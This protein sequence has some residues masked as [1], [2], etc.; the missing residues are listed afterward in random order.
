MFL[1]RKCGFRFSDQTLRNPVFWVWAK[2]RESLAIM[3]F[4]AQI[5]DEGLQQALLTLRNRIGIFG[6]DFWNAIRVDE[7]V[8]LKYATRQAVR[9]VPLSRPFLLRLHFV[10]DD[11]RR[12][13]QR[14]SSTKSPSQLL[15]RAL[16]SLF[17]LPQAV[18]ASTFA[19]ST[20]N[21]HFTCYHCNF[22]LFNF[23]AKTTQATS[24]QGKR[25][26]SRPQSTGCRRIS[27]R[28]RSSGTLNF[29]SAAEQRYPNPS[30]NHGVC[31]INR[32]C[33]MRSNFLFRCLFRS[34]S[35]Y[36]GVT[37]CWKPVQYTGYQDI[38]DISRIPD[39]W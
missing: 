4:S 29:S 33:L 3:Y 1:T 6:S 19:S 14:H 10:C 24:E 25:H 34:P 17:Y 22:L 8:G 37:S 26:L 2:I 16:H 7:G 30:S 12:E 27:P 9:Q 15:M 13:W 35:W 23:M 5:I 38:N 28:R 11:D 20:S 31:P 36:Q 39:T 32:V 18:S 21:L